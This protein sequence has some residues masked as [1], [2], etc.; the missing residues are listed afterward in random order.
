M[1]VQV[2]NRG[3]R[4]EIYQRTLAAVRAGIAPD[5]A[6]DDVSLLAVRAIGCMNRHARGG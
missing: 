6:P 3:A 2:L 5:A 4:D 1:P